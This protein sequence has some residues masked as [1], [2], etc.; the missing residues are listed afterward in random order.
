MIGST[1]CLSAALLFV[2]GWLFNED[3]LTAVTQTLLWCIIFFFASAAASSAY[4]T[5]SEIFPV[6]LRAQAISFFFA[7][8]VLF[9]GVIAPWLFAM[10]IG[11]GNSRDR[12]FL[13]YTIASI[14]M[15]V[16]GLVAFVWGI[17][18]ERR[19]LEA[20]ATPMSARAL[21]AG[22]ESGLTGGLTSHVR[23]SRIADGAAEEARRE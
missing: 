3:A 20:V 15:L 14:L 16:G 17:D 7:L 11:D 6:E 2:T 8:A 13:G 21:A 23:R 10:L 9:G 19:P 1:Y 12:I 18:A 5:V 22:A 4:L